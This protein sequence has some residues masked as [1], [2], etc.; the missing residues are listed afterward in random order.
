MDE[1]VKLEINE[2]PWMFNYRFKITKELFEK[3]EK[4]SKD[5]AKSILLGRILTNE[6]YLNVTYSKSLTDL[7]KI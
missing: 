4:T 3:T 6:Y 1:Y 7:I 5:L 2:L